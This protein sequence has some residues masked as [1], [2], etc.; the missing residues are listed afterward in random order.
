MS[1]DQSMQIGKKAF[2]SAVLIILT[3]MIVSGILTR[4]IPSGEYQ[5]VEIDGRQIVV[6]DSFSYIDKPD[7]PIWRWF[8]A[9]IEVLWGDNAVGLI[10]II[11]FLIFVG[12]A[13]AI[14]DKGG[15]LKSV[16]ALVVKRFQT[17]KYLLMAIIIFIF[18]FAAAV[19]GIFEAMVP[20]VIFI[21][22]LAHF[23]GWDSL[24]GLG[25]SLLAVAFGF[26]AAITNP[27]SIGIAQSIAELPI[28]SGA[29]LRVIFFITIYTL[30]FWYVRRYAKMI[31]ADPTK[32]LV[33]EEDKA[34]KAHFAP[35]QIEKDIELAREP[36]MRNSMIFFS[37]IVG[38]AVGFIIVASQVP[39][40]SMLAFPVMGLLLFTGG[41]GAGLISGM[42]TSNVAK[43]FAGGA[44]QILPAVLLVMM[45]MSV[46]HIIVQ[47]GVMDTILYH[48][49]GKIA[50]TSAFS[51]IFL[52]Y[53][54]TLGLNFFI[55]SASAK[56]FLMMP[57][58]TPL[59][60]L[61]GITRQT[62]VLAFDFGD[63]FSN[64]LYPTNALLLVALGLTVVSYPKWIRW[65]IPLQL[66]AF[67]ISLGFLAFA[68][69]I[70]F[71]PF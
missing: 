44:L 64:M 46:Q 43:S 15:I 2:V 33:Y 70:N 68:T 52:V 62:V 55:G 30:T 10:T 32:S 71:G 13:F 59:A 57:I 5:R 19:L 31:E 6:A 63:G 9:P 65:V 45:A 69:A 35:E 1:E 25:M 37:V 61:V 14:L 56:A 60:D 40:I 47:G 51:A 11:I 58:L 26:S 54:L 22:P 67:V 23:M 39:S 8:T 3:L 48:A 41:I 27:F 29:W 50:E 12:G 20:L 4:M 21:V 18:M 17:R 34:I 42:G 28:F 38:L 66:M 36:R 49:S 7:Y 53:A 16:L 24:T